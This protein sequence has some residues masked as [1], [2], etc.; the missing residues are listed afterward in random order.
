ML[1]F[2]EK[3]QGRLLGHVCGAVGATIGADA[4]LARFA[5]NYLALFPYGL[6]GVVI[7]LLMVAL[8]ARIVNEN[9]RCKPKGPWGG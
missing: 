3:S 4:V 5:Q 1:R 9:R 7:S 8:G 6:S 2:D